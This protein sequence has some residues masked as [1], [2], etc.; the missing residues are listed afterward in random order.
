M[1]EI[2][3]NELDLSTNNIR[4]LAPDVRNMRSL[5][6]LDVSRNPIQCQHP[7][8][9]SGFPAEISQLPN[10][11]VIIL[12]ECSLTVLPPAIWNCANLIA[13]DVSRN[14][15]NKLPAE[16]GQLTRLRYLSVQQTGLTTVPAEIACCRR[17][18]DLLLWGNSI[19]S[20]PASIK[21]LKELRRL[22]LTCRSFAVGMDKYMD[23]LLIS[24]QIQSEHVPPVLLE[25]PRLEALDLDNTKINQL[26][27]S[28]TQQPSSVCVN[29]IVLSLANN[30]L[31]SLPQHV[32]DMNRL[33]SLDISHNLLGELPD[34][35]GDRLTQLEILQ[36]NG[37]Q[38]TTCPASIGNLSQ[39]NLLSM[40]GNKLVQLPREIGQ[41]K[42]L[43]TLLLES[44]R[45]TQLPDSLAEL[46]SLE[47]LVLSDNRLTQLPVNMH[48]MTSLTSAHAF[49]K[50]NKYGL[51]LHPNEFLNSPPAAVWRS[52]STSRLFQYLAEMR[53]STSAKHIHR[54]K[55]VV[56]GN[57]GSGKTELIN[58]LMDRCVTLQE[59]RNLTSSVST[60]ALR[61]WT[62][63]NR[64]NF[65][66]YD[67]SG[68]ESDDLLLPVWFDSWGPA[69]LYVVVF[70]ASTLTSDSFHTFIG[71]WIDLLALHVPGA[72]VKFVGSH[73]DALN[74]SEVPI[75]D[76]KQ[77][78][79]RLIL[80]HVNARESCFQ[81]L[82]HNIEE[83]ATDTCSA[84]SSQTDVA[85]SFCNSESRKL[86]VVENVSFVGCS[87]SDV[88]KLTVEIELTVTSDKLFA[89][90]FRSIENLDQIQTFV[91]T[92]RKQRTRTLTV[93]WDEVQEAAAAAGLAE[94]EDLLT[95]LEFLCST[96]E[97]LWFRSIPALNGVVFTRPARLLRVLRQCFRNPSRDQSIDNSQMFL[98][99]TLHN[100]DSQSFSE[101]KGKFLSE[102]LASRS[103]L[104]YLLFNL[105]PTN[106]DFLEVVDILCRMDLCCVISPSPI[107]LLFPN[108]LKTCK[109]R[110][111]QFWPPAKGHLRR[112]VRFNFQELYP[113]HLMARLS[114]RLFS[115]VSRRYVHASDL[116][117]DDVT[118]DVRS[119]VKMCSHANGD[120]KSFENCMQSV[121]ELSIEAAGSDEEE[122][123]NC[124]SLLREQ[125]ESILKLYKGQTF[126]VTIKFN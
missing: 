96:G 114:C 43:K 124:L 18:T 6:Y 63:P 76:W 15:I 82:Y 11:R 118:D 60:S 98:T 77:Q 24:G 71:R 29:M 13:L 38:I 99:T 23:S 52:G 62:T 49:R 33:T 83:P 37:N 61:L 93:E 121:G 78:V 100:S 28:G 105:R 31:P 89:T 26:P 44:N 50:L 92:M 123:E 39:L 8:D 56:I 120:E 10:L 101:A 69:A 1:A 87:S 67:M 58:G 74:Q 22:E 42:R 122:L 12:S 111:H 5:V 95:A 19:R 30:F 48:Q 14:R 45:L 54:Q 116:F 55:L 65:T 16:V 108:R 75:N 106:D 102:G 119:L 73:A 3:V 109:K 46:T 104:L 72:V 51:W 9:F 85:D 57:C 90:N 20:L 97:V 79:E 25:L 7:R 110:I 21:Y 36:L 47:T 86:H 115:M 41:L 81:K 103:F 94:E 66:I 88:A 2:T 68:C 117:I 80:D 53:L 126:S 70:N 64:I 113:T 125:V 112:R 27:S 40:N 4:S 107:S 17:L 34:N 91:R 35:I 32:L 59:N 84:Q